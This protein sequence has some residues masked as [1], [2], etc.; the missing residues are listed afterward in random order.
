MPDME[1]P[2][3]VRA[4][5]DEHDEERPDHLVALANALVEKRQAA[6]NARTESGIEEVWR[7]AEEAY[8]G[9]DDA[10][11]GQFM[12]A[13]WAKPLTSA[14]PLQITSSPGQ[15]G[16]AKS[17]AYVRLTSRYV[18]A[19]SAKVSQILL[20][21]NGKAFGFTATPVPDIAEALKS[22]E[23]VVE[24][25]RPLTRDARPT[26]QV[27]PPGAGVVPQGIPSAASPA[28]GIPAAPGSPPQVPLRKRD[29][30]QEKLDQANTSAKKSE[31]RIYDWMVESKYRREM[32]KVIFDMARIGVGV[33]KGPY[34]ERVTSR[35]RGDEKLSVKTLVEVK[36]SYTWRDPWNIYPDPACGE[37]IQNGSYL[38]DLDFYSDKQVRKLKNQPGYIV[39]QLDK[40]LL[41]GP[42]GY[43]GTLPVQAKDDEKVR[44]NKFAVWFYYGTI[45]KEEYV[46][47]ASR[48]GKDVTSEKLEDEV[49]V[50]CTVINN[51]VVRAII[52]PVDSGDLPYHG[53]P[54]TRRAGQWAGVGVGEQLEMPQR[55]INAATRAMFNNA[56]KSAGSVIVFDDDVIEPADGN[57]VLH[58]DKVFRKKPGASMEDVRKSFFAF[59][60]PNKT[61][62]LMLVIDYA[63]RM[64]EEVTNIPLVTQGQSGN[65]QPETYGGMALQNNNANQL[66]RNIGYQIDDYITEPVVNQ[67]YEYLLLDPDVPEDEKG[68]WKIDAHGS[69]ALVERAIQ[70]E[71]IRQM[72]QMA[73]NP[74]FGVDPKRWFAAFSRSNNLDPKDFQFTEEEQRVRDQTPPP[75]PYQVQVA[76][77]RSADNKEQMRTDAQVEQMRS[78]TATAIQQAADQAKLEIAQMRKEVDQLRVQKDT[79]RDTVYVQAE[80]SRVE[81]EHEARMKEIALKR[82]LAMLDYANKHSLQLEQVKADLAKTQMTLETQIKL[83]NVKTVASGGA[84][85]PGKAPNGKGFSA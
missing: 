8:L 2:D 73:L 9:V 56:G 50:I 48:A 39:S 62:D 60:V 83:A 76:Q 23:Q 15:P 22:D 43:D 85:P 72:S 44:K 32:R 40:V 66:L 17:T 51:I 3:E 63:L 84:E 6:V 36:P 69:S 14:G 79:D 41:E 55:A 67:S 78:E 35:R 26:D 4:A 20:P 57:Y 61:K 12:K 30:A 45:K 10:N 82:E 31:T 25:G 27:P 80:T 42:L 13:R 21:A 24:N 29:L 74:A 33:L 34:P 47:A 70:D 38:F 11:R 28:A 1:L 71:T 81:A 5:L 65:T 49:D 52:S 19:G 64:A 59:Q 46:E 68:D 54:W 75:P 37:D 77:I 16:E 18:D 7:R 53:C 58:P